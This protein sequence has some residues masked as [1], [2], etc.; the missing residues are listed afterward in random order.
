MLPGPFGVWIRIAF[1][2]HT[3]CCLRGQALGTP[4]MDAGPSE[5]ARKPVNG[6]PSL[7]AAFPVSAA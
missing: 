2:A 1:P 4:S 6:R 7:D 3:P 5:G